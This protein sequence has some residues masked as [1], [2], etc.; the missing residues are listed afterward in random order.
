LAYYL[1]NANATT[2]L[3]TLADDAATRFVVEQCLEEAKDDV[4]LDHDEVRS[5]PAWHRHVTLSMM[6]LA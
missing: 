5:W 4:G 2:A 6:A 1:F 3:T